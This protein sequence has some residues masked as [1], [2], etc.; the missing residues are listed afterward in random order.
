MDCADGS[1]IPRGKSAEP[2]LTADLEEPHVHQSSAHI[3][4]VCNNALILRHEKEKMVKCSFRTAVFILT[5]L[6]LMRSSA[7]PVDQYFGALKDCTR[8]GSLQPQLRHPR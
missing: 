1:N 7:A 2:A 3:V 4:Y 6:L 8:R 5:A